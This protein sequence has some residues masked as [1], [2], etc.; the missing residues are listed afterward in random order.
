MKVMFG[1][2]FRILTI[3]ILITQLNVYSQGV[4]IENKSSDN[5]L[6]PSTYFS[7]LFSGQVE[8]KEPK[9]LKLPGIYKINP[10]LETSFIMFERK[11]NISNDNVIYNLVLEDMFSNQAMIK[12][13]N[14]FIENKIIRL[15]Y[16]QSSEYA[17][18]YTHL[19]L[20]TKLAV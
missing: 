12:I 1:L 7:T 9:Q 13:N 18:S 10:D 3:I 20:P 4:K 17:V 11:F 2:L 8:K 19:T 14:Q 5:V 15:D 16:S 6:D